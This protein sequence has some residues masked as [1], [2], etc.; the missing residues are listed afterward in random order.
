MENITI[1]FKITLIG[2]CLLV[3]ITSL[4]FN[5]LY[6]KLLNFYRSRLNSYEV[7]LNE[8]YKYS[9]ETMKFCLNAIINNSIKD[10]VQDF[11]TAKRCQEL[12]NKL[13]K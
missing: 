1:Y 2:L 9:D 5:I 10:D 7:R 4:T 8:S 13:S 3:T 11:E 12:I 6:Y